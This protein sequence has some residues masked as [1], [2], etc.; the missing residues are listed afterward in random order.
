[1]DD[2]SQRD[3]E[4]P[5]ALANNHRVSGSFIAIYAAA[6]GGLWMALLPPA[7][8]GLQLRMQALNPDHAT[9]SLSLVV[10]V[11]ALVALVS[12]P[13][14]GHW[15]DRTTWRFG[16]R[17]PWLIL[18]AFGGAAGLAMIG[19]ASSIA[20]VLL[21]WCVAQL[22]YNALLAALTAIFSDQIPSHQRGTVSGIIGISLPIGM[23]GGTYL[24]QAVTG[25]I[26]AMLLLPAAVCIASALLLAWAL[27][28]RR[29][30][31]SSLPRHGLGEFIAGFWVDP[32]RFSD[33]AWAWLSRV[34]LFMGVTV[35]M[36]YQ[37]FYLTRQL[38]FRQDEVP[39]LIFL[40]TLA[41]YSV[42]AVCGAVSGRLSDAL[43]RRKIFV[44]AAASIYACAL[45]TIAFSTTYTQFIA[46]MMIAGMG[47]GIYQTVDLALI[48]DVLPNREMDAA[49][50]LGMFNIASTL[51]QVLMPALAPTILTLGNG[52]YTVLFAIA[53]PFAALS[54]LAIGPVRGTR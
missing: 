42:V 36:T 49:K 33:F 31:K 22:A 21:G 38:G 4:L 6:Y 8:A 50:N 9:A 27:P 34:L 12:N 10:S 54:A 14:F 46:A 32:R 25:S 24:A 43:R 16:M 26:L 48:A 19:A 11:G 37:V 41:Q 18:G 7:L 17:R 47:F 23:V 53:A 29:L 20:M 52:S 28:D 15:S 30:V 51:P 3:S 13:L 40:S 2:T 1:M 5:R 35:L 39:R 44:F 45:L